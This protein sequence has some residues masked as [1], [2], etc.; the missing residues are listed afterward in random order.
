MSKRTVPF[1]TLE[2][3]EE[4]MKKTIALLL[5]LCMLFQLAACSSGGSGSS[6]SS[7]EQTEAVLRDP[8]EDFNNH[9]MQS[10]NEFVSNT[11]CLLPNLP[12]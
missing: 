10:Y 11:L 8:Y 6:V 7:P 1:D 9:Y 12:M 5:L 4:A 3:K 2:E